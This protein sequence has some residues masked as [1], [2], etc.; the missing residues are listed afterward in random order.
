MSDFELS[1]SLHIIIIYLAFCANL[2][3]KTSFYVQKT[4]FFGNSVVA[5]QKIASFRLESSVNE[6]WLSVSEHIESIG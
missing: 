5:T 2:Y 3:S 6:L 1:T 4:M